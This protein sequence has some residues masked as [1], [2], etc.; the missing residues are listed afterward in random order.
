MFNFS[1]YIVKQLEWYQVQVFNIINP[2][3]KNYGKQVRNWPPY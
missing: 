1:D 3:S 2:K